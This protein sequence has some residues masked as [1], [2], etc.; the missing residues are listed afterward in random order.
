MKHILLLCLLLNLLTAVKA[1]TAP[2]RPNIIWITCEDISPY[3]S[4][5]GDSTVQTPHIDQ[6]AREGVLYTRA[7]TTAGVCAPSRAAI[8][9]GMHQQSIGAHHMR[10]RLDLP[11]MKFSDLPEAIRSSLSKAFPPGLP[12][13]SVLLPPDVRPYPE[14]LRQAGYYATNNEKTDYQFE[15]PVTT[16]DE[17]GPAASYRNRP[18]GMPFFAVFNL[19]VTHESQ[20]SARKE[21]LEVNPDS[22]VVPPYFPDT[23]TVRN[24]VARVLTNIRIMDR[25]VGEIIRQ[26]KAD[27]VYEHSYIF[28]YSDHGGPLPWQKRAVLDRGTH[29]PLI[30]RM[31][32]GRDAGTIDRQLVSSVDFAPTVLSLAGIPVPSHMQGQALLGRQR[33]AKPRTYVYAAADRMDEHY[34][35]VRSMRDN[36]YLYIRNFHPELPRYMDISYRIANI[37]MMREILRL[38]DSGNLGPYT[39]A[40]FEAPKPSEELYD[41]EKDPHQLHNLAQDP[42]YAGRLR[43]MRE[44]YDAWAKKTGDMGAIPEKDMVSSWW[45]GQLEPPQTEK[46]TITQT[47]NGLLI[48][49]GTAGA[50]IGYKIIKKGDSAQVVKRPVLSWDG[51]FISGRVRPGATIDV[52]FPWEIYSGKAIRLSRGDK[53]IVRAQRIGYAQAEAEFIQP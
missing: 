15:T 28:F 5:Y 6:L 16:W 32:G 30:I 20:I 1:Q 48:G 44:T 3:L 11:G 51:A 29:I 18:A 27:G 31:P 10:T 25:Q 17:L 4:C 38:R 22:V 53:L 46:P 43:D 24:D 52:P 14:Y 37:P 40:W 45:Q 33:A 26:L 23:R 12:F 2:D 7:F 49:C 8:I 41:T 36:R 50:S 13:Y 42:A 35:R 19:M 9:T 21:P 39:R 34:D 47:A